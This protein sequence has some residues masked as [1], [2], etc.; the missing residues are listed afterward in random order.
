[1]ARRWSTRSRP[2]VW[3]QI[4]FVN[5]YLGRSEQ[6]IPA[7]EHSLGL[8]PRQPKV[9]Q[10]LLEAYHAE[11]RRE[12]VRRVHARLLELDRAQ[13]EQAYHDYLLPYEAAR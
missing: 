2:I 4:G 8:D 9:W 1:M 12:D 11:G 7:L 6:S 3:R 13:A 5:A 10:A